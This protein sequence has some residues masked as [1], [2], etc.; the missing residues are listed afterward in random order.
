[1]TMT[2]LTIIPSHVVQTDMGVDWPTL[3]QFAG[4]IET[5][6]KHEN[7][8][9]IKKKNIKVSLHNGTII[10]NRKI[11]ILKITLM[12]LDTYL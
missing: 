10:D 2:W 4:C 12:L 7:V 8:L 3:I 1:M 9:S 11:Q 6:K 5:Q